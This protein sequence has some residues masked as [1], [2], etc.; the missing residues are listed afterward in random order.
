MNHHMI[1]LNGSGIHSWKGFKDIHHIVDMEL[2]TTL[3]MNIGD[4][5]L[6][7][8]QDRVTCSVLVRC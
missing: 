1:G 3:Y 8:Q 4:I 5:V 2:K 7:E 6:I